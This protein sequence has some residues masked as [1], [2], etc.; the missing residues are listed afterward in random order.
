M[1]RV[2]DLVAAQGWFDTSRPFEKT[3]NLTQGA[4]LWMMLTR[5]GVCDTYVKFSESVSLALEAQRCDSASRSY[6]TLV[7]PYVGHLH[8]AG[9]DVLV[10][11]AVAYRAPNVH[12]LLS[13]RADGRVFQDLGRY[14]AAMPATRLSPQLTP[15]GNAGLVQGLATYFETHSLAPLAR[16]WLR[17]D[18]VQR[19]SQLPDMPQHGD[20][21]V[22]NIGLAPDGSAVV[23][24][25][26]DFGASCLPGLDLFTLELSLAG[27][28]ARLYAGRGSP[29]SPL[30][31][32]VRSACHA[33]QL[34]H[35]DYSTLTTVYALV[36]R[37]LKR[38]Y[39]PGVRERMDQL[40]QDLDQQRTET[41]V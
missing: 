13:G 41:D 38:N 10:C 9:L 18:A 2:L 24:D 15:V 32:F 30:Q 39:G 5:Q 1:K 35:G 27:D 21:V 37:H 11:R 33:M 25:W 20:M 26:E 36:F 3:I 29:S 40:L 14:F 23:F 16:R 22:N 34:D 6:P 12:K 4:C 28:A 31:Q 8:E 17:S 7:P 19:A